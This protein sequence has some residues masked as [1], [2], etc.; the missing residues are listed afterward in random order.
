MAS[1]NGPGATDAGAPLSARVA[2]VL[3]D[4]SAQPLYTLILTFLFAPYFANAVAADPTVGQ[5]WWTYSLAVAGVLIAV[6]SPFLGAL[7]DSGGRR[8]PWI[9]A[10]VIVM[11][12]AMSSLWLAKPKADTLSM[13][14]ILAA[15]VA[16]Y[17]AGEFA[18]V[19]TNT[20]L[21]ALVPPGRIGRLSG[22]GY[23]V[24]YA[25]GLASLLIMAGLIVA[26]PTTGRT[27]LGLV[28]LLPLDTAMREGDRL[29]GPFAA[30]WLAVFVLPFFLFVPEGRR[31]DDTSRRSS[32]LGELGSTIRSLPSQPN[33][34]LFFV[35]RMIY[36]DGLTAIF[37]LGGIYGTTV[38]GWTAFELGIFG[39]IL[40][41]TGAIG[42][43]VGGVLDDTRGA[44]WV[45]VG[46]LV[47]LM[48]AATGILSVTR[49]QI[50][51]GL[52]TYTPRPDGA[53]PF[54]SVGEIV[55]LMF[56][57]V[58]GFVAAPVQAASRSL[59]ARLAP[60]EK[61]TQYFGL[62]AF[63]GKA[64]AFMAPLLVGIVTGATGS[65]R[66]GVA[67]IILFVGIGLL[68]MLPIRDRPTQ[69]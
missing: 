20:F 12:A 31:R 37:G 45:I 5:Q 14:L 28:P 54:T 39:I 50:L 59:I 26:N 36:V 10:F 4:F 67:V 11:I 69:A 29:A 33:V 16:A 49:E 18:T 43:L 25:G 15:F 60:P 41:L 3:F 32:A 1:R 44:K 13:V 19:F 40:S 23:A 57:M 22:I 9:L 21:P 58:I 27:L 42:A 64:T 61:I 46:S 38:F 53:L 2:W 52:F 51:Y 68:L 35:A 47:L 62:F 17:S 55:Y 48:L 56:A 63:S 66:L 30:L 65:Q 6:G 34:L 8:K 24:G 7:A